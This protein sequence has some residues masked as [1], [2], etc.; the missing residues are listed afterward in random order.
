M[1]LKRQFKAYQDGA[2]EIEKTMLIR[3]QDAGWS[4]SKRVRYDSLNHVD[5]EVGIISPVCNSYISLDF[6]NWANQ[7]KNAS[8]IVKEA[9]ILIESEAYK[10]I[11]KNENLTENL[12]TLSNE[13]RENDLVNEV[14]NFIEKDK[15]RP[16]CTP[17]S[18]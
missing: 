18:K 16:I 1:I 10:E 13:F 3:L 4:A 15:K 5:L 2:L 7:F 17:F 14:V 6:K 11:F 8:F 12:N 9:A